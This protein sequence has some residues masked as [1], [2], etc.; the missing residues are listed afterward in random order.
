MPRRTP[1]PAPGALIDRAS[2]RAVFAELVASALGVTR[3]RPT[4]MAVAYL[5]ELLDERVR[6]PESGDPAGEETLAEALLRARLERGAARVRRLREAG[7]RALFVAGFFGDSLSRRP[8]GLGYYRDAGRA[9]YAG[10]AAELARQLRERSWPHLF[11]ELAD[12][13]G[14]FVDV[15]AEVSDRTAARSAPGLLRL[16]VRYLETGSARDWQRLVRRGGVPVE[17]AAFRRWQ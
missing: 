17:R 15:L 6:A 13:F 10:L 16:Y 9:A 11:E 14:D 1:D 8:V 3:V 5:I 2:P 7:D 12:R 4:P